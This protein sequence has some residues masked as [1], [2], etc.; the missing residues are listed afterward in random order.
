M[1]TRLLEQ[2]L[3]DAVYCVASRIRYAACNV[4]DINQIIQQT[5]SYIRSEYLKPKL[6]GKRKLSDSLKEAYLEELNDAEIIATEKIQQQYFVCRKRRDIALIEY[7]SLSL[8]VSKEL[9]KRQ[10]PYILE[11]VMDENILTV[12][13]TS[14]YFFDIPLSLEN[15]EKATDLLEYFIMR[16]DCAKRE[17][18]E[19]RKRYDPKLA[20]SW[21]E[22]A[23]LGKVI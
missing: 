9:G 20:S 23:S 7:P 1:M 4:G 18:P 10:I 5:V 8:I 17:M 11:T 19:I 2:L 15:V 21:K 22:A 3:S 13:I 16:P 12:H 6:H 14:E